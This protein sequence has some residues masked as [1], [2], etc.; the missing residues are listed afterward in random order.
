MQPFQIMETL[1]WS[2]VRCLDF[3][4]DNRLQEHFQAAALSLTSSQFNECIFKKNGV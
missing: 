1:L 3:T 4:F 2:G